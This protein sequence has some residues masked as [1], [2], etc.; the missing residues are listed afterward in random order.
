[1]KIMKRHDSPIENSNTAEGGY[2]LLAVTVF[3]FVV[4]LGGMAIFSTTSSESRLATYGQEST[5]AFYLADGAIERARARLSNDSDWRTGWNNVAAGNGTYSLTLR[6]TLVGGDPGVAMTAIGEVRRARRAIEAVAELP[7]TGTPLAV[8]SD[9]W[10]YILGRV[11]IYD[12][13]HCNGNVWTGF[14][15]NG[16]QAGTLTDE[17]NIP[18]LSMY[19]TA[20]RFPNTTYYDVRCVT[21]GGPARAVIRDGDGNDITAVL[22]DDMH[23]VVQFSNASR[24]FT[25]TF[26]GVGNF[27]RYFHPTTGLFVKAPGDSAVV[28][29]FGNP[30]EAGPPGTRDTVAIYLLGSNS[31]NM[32]IITQTLINTRF[33]GSS[34]SQRTTSSAWRGEMIYTSNIT[35][36]PENGIAIISHYHYATGNGQS[37][38]GTVDQPAFVYATNSAY[39][40]WGRVSHRGSVASLNM[41]LI[42]SIIGNARVEYTWDG[43]FLGDVPFWLA[44]QWPG[45]TAATLNI[46]SWREIPPPSS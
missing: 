7:A 15:N 37:S 41:W 11:W 36:E 26:N 25:I 46:A 21:G 32:P 6:D 38:I 44:D 31:A 4:I 20:D 23:T 42:L 10:A 1:M 17:P 29:N 13:A 9:R 45:G 43:G 2:V 30:P 33:T 3:V 18:M 12:R 27:N 39:V 28:V 35:M 16:I 14:G 34:E 19:T 22:G 8:W 5:E 40:L 24:R